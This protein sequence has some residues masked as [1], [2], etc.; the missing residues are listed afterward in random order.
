MKQLFLFALLLVA[1]CGIHAVA[2]DKPNVI[3]IVADDQGY[4]DLSC[5]GNPVLKTPELDKLHQ[6]SIRFTNFHVAPMCSPTRGEILTGLAAFRNGATAVCQ[7]RS[8]P[9]RELTMLP[10]YLKQNGYT[11]GHFGKWHL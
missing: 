10:Q 2:A 6:E 11:T 9:R 5:H 7:G 4:G 1:M 8:L 3:L